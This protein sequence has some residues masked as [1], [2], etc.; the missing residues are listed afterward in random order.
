MERPAGSIPNHKYLYGKTYADALKSNEEETA[1]WTAYRQEHV[2]LKE[3]I[4]MYQ[5]S[6]RTD[7]LIPVGSK[8][9][10]PGQL[11]HTG[12]LLVSHGNGYFSECSSEQAQSIADRRIRVANDMLQKY[13]RER[14]LH[15]DKLDAPFVREAF[16]DGGGQEILEVY[17]EAA[18]KRWREKHRHRVREHKQREARERAKTESTTE[19]EHGDD[20]LFKH[21]EEMELLEELEHEIDQLD[22][23]PDDAAN[24]QL[25]RL[26]RGEISLNEKP[27][28]AHQ[29]TSQDNVEEQQIQ[30]QEE[31]IETTDDEST[32]SREDDK[33]DEDNDEN[34]TAEF[35]Q[36]LNDTKN[37]GE[38]EK[39]KIFRAKLRE[40]R[41]Q[42]YTN[43]ISI[44]EK[45]DLYQLHEEIEEAL[46]FLQLPSEED[47]ERAEVQDE[48]EAEAKATKRKSKKIKFAEHDQIKLIDGRNS[49]VSESG[50][51]TSK[52]AEKTLFLPIVHS[53]DTLPEAYRTHGTGST[54]EIL[55]PADIYRLFAM[56]TEAK[57]PS[58]VEIR[59]R[60]SILKNKQ[61]PQQTD[62]NP[63]EPK[64]TSNLA[65]RPLSK[66][67][68]SV[69]IIGEIVEHAVTDTKEPPPESDPK[70]RKNKKV[71]RFKQQ[72][73]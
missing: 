16:A 18:E 22:I 30:D 31:E 32:G 50:V 1:R 70:G 5:Q 55:S 34:L 62:R 44:I 54:E 57:V 35:Q 45:V 8:A 64:T 10:L 24:E 51:S 37:C 33:E 26:M 15:S 42:L 19:N 59:H 48:P 12:E 11:Y 72:R 56:E 28:I 6:L 71:S 66:D 25:Q 43:S 23:A 67:T 60:K 39:I 58:T 14:M 61:M 29:E 9:L 46:D 53:P 73:Q 38:E 7:I 36:L 21:L 2:E 3:N 13:E 49:S 69:A 52:G 68:P 40:V 17:D 20:D 4:R 47:G 65:S 63:V 27:R 41:Q